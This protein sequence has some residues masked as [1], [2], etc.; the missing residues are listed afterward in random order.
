MEA[1]VR[2]LRVEPDKTAHWG[3][4][5]AFLPSP[6]CRAIMTAA[7]YGHVIKHLEVSRAKHGALGESMELLARAGVERWFEVGAGAV[8]AGLRRGIV[9]VS[10]CISFREAKEIEKVS[11][12]I[13]S[14]HSPPRP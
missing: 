12:A 14:A 5:Y 7:Q 4:V 13:V 8:L 11:S 6:K 9:P 2:P 10:K 1:G 3:W